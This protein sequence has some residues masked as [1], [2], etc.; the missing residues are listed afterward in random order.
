MRSRL[1]WSLSLCWFG[2]YSYCAACAASPEQEKAE[3]VV[4]IEALGGSVAVDNGEPSKPV[5]D[6]NLAHLAVI[7]N[8]DLKWLEPLTSLRRLCLAEPRA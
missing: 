7:G 5:M 3:A 1:S 2:P 4:R 6:V 8:A